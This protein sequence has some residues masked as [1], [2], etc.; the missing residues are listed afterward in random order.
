MFCQDTFKES[1][2]EECNCYAPDKIWLKIITHIHI[3]IN[4]CRHV[5]SQRTQNA[6]HTNIV[7]V[8]HC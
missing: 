6:G 7:S 4:I 2:R 1:Q 5:N 8:V 3:Y